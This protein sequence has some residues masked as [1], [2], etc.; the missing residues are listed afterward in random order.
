MKRFRN[1]LHIFTI[2]ISLTS[3]SQTNNP[4]AD[5][6]AIVISGNARFTILT[7]Q[8]IRMEWSEKG[9]F[10]DKA[11]LV[12]INRNL[13]VPEF[14][15]K[16]SKEEL[17]ITTDQLKLVYKKTGK[18]TKD[19][20]SIS[21]QLNNKEQL[22][23]PDS[24]D[25]RN[26]FGTTRTLDGVYNEADV[27]LE[28]G[29]ISRNG[30]AVID[31]SKRHLFDG[32]TDWN[33]ILP[34]TEANRQDLYFFGYGHDYKK[35]LTDYTLVAGKIPIPP[36]FAFGYWWSR[37]WDYSDEEFRTLIKDFR[38]N[39]IPIDVLIIDM[40]WHN[41]WGIGTKYG[42][43]DI[44][45]QE[46]GWTGYTWN[47]NLFPNP[48]KFL[49]WTDKMELK[50]ALNLHPASGIAP[51]ED[52]YNRF[53]KAYNFDT[54][55]RPY[56]PF[57]IE[58]KKWAKTYFNE[59][60][61][62]LEKTGIDFWWLDWQQWL[63]NKGVKGLSNTWWL[64]Y[65]FFTDMERRGEKRPF[66]FHRWGGMGN[67][68][69]Q[70]GFS[71]DA[72][73]NWET[74]DYETYFTHTAS[75]VCYGYWSHDIGGHQ[76][77]DKDPELYLR[78]LQ[79]GAYSPIL[80]THCTKVGATDRRLWMY[81]N[82]FEM[83]RDAIYTRYQ[84]EP[85]IYQNARNAY[86]NGISICRP[87]YYDYPEEDK[88]YSFKHQYFFGNDLIVAPIATKADALTGLS[89]K[90]IWLPEGEWFEMHSGRMLKGNQVIKRDFAMSEVPVYAKAGSIIPMN[91]PVRN[92]ANISDTMVLVFIPGKGNTT[93]N[94]YEDDGTTS[95]YQKNEYCTTS[96]NKNNSNDSLLIINIDET[97][98]SYKGMSAKKAYQLQLPNCM[99]PQKVV[100]NNE[101]YKYSYDGGDNTWNYDGKTLTL[102]INIPLTA[103]NLSQTVKI[104][105]SQLLNN[106]ESIL[107]G[108]RE[109]FNRLPK[110]AEDMK[111]EVCNLNGSNPPEAF[112]YAA[113]LAASITYYP[114]K[115]IDILNKYEQNKND[116]LT[117][118]MDIDNITDEKLMYW[119]RYL[120][121]T[122]EMLKQPELSFTKDDD[123]NVTITIKKNDRNEVVHYTLN[124]KKPDNTSPVYKS[125]IKASTPVNIRAIA[126]R[127]GRINSLISTLTFA[128]NPVKKCIFVNPI[129]DKYTGG[130]DTALFD[131]KMG[132]AGNFMVKWTG[133]E[134]KDFIAQCNLKK[135]LELK[136]ISV[137]FLFKP[138]SWIMLPDDIIVEASVDDI[139]YEVVGNIKPQLTDKNTLQ[140]VFTYTV[141]FKNA[142]KY[143]SFRLTAKTTGKLPAWHEYPGQPSWLFTDEILLKW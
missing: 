6:K 37:Y 74:L 122:D 121:F 131:G 13:K 59:V 47:R 135:P 15:T 23:T 99:P 116:M 28:D 92:L 101:E 77:Q 31:D 123:H 87:M 113:G 39:N 48:D 126:T 71:G 72:A 78:W 68:R 69:Y 84:L 57:K 11:S 97:K 137:R 25:D 127:E 140:D 55:G 41:T 89:T 52:C 2:L 115:V 12:F 46:V 112:L 134:K 75:N 100:V 34:R 88:A 93:L 81:P 36:R 64:N 35:A 94:Y 70:I 119:F 24:K 136:E 29:L 51:F 22:W 132:E 60:L 105:P 117:E 40:E 14:K 43:R 130:S 53:A 96:I 9:I 62:P 103:R 120:G 80:R 85:Y 33:W 141:P 139:T 42:K 54:T 102:I 133:I 138:S 1:L 79:F 76:G 66:L 27:K 86:D 124:G 111:I 7:S 65:T 26:L 125:S 10:E 16:D 61:H 114:D 73:S 63:E 45:D 4:V 56:I 118:I 90:E 38:R 91:P 109:L 67:H 49:D 83:M 44:F 5:S 21:F 82:Q 104:Y 19:N 95:S 17:I 58:E 32:S 20:L 108:K 98:G 128:Y 143:T 142:K 129:S 107:D 110:I 8:L 3:M 50:T 18:F 30:W 106:K